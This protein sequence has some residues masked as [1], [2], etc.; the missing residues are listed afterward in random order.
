MCGGHTCCSYVCRP[1]CYSSCYYPRD[2]YSSCCY[3]S[4]YYPRSCY[5]SCCYRSCCSPC[6]RSCCSPCCSEYERV[7]ETVPVE[8]TYTTYETKVTWRKRGEKTEDKKEDE[9]KK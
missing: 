8:H 4:C 9:E 2:C 1:A 3:S 5:L 6:Y 7:V